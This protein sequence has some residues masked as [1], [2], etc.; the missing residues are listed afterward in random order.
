M[1]VEL[2]HQII[3]KTCEGCGKT[4]AYDLLDPKNID[5]LQQ[6]VKH[7]REVWLGNQWVKLV[8]DSCCAEC[9]AAA[10][11]KTNM[12][13]EADIPEID[14]ASLRTSEPIN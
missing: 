14:L 10:V 4:T 12:P 8:T 5:A 13:P 1:S 6:W 2:M 11:E 7:I 9:V 3:N